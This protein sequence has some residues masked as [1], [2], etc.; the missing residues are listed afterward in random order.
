MNNSFQELWQQ[1]VA[2][3]KEVGAAQRISIVMAGLVVLLGLAGVAVWS[4]REDY[5]VL[6]GNLGE[7]EAAKVVN[8]LDEAKVPYKVRGGGTISVPADKVHPL[9]IQLAGKGIPGGGTTGFSLFDKPNFGIS[10]FVQRVNYLRAIQGELSQTIS[11]VDGI[12]SAQ[13]MLVMPE[14]RLLV[15]Y[16][17]KPSAS[18]F[19]KLRGNVPVPASTVNAIRF[20]VANAVEGLTPDGVSITDNIGNLLT[21]A[22]DND[23]I[24]GATSSQ[25]KQR[26]EYESY[27]AKKVESFLAPYV[28]GPARVLARVSVD[29]DYTTLQRRETKYDPES[30][31]KRTETITDER[32]DNSTSNLTGAVGAPGTATNANV[33][34]NSPAGTAPMTKNNTNKKVTQNQYEINEV[35]TTQNH[36]PGSTKRI[37]AAVFI[38]LEYTGEGT[39]RVAAPRSPADM[40]K[41]R[42]GIQA[43]L[44]IIERGEAGRVDDLTVEEIAFNDQPSREL[45]QQLEKSERQRL[46]TEIARESVF[47]IL[48]V[49]V[50][51]MLWRLFQKTGV[52]E[53]P[54][55][56]PIGAASAE[57]AGA[58]GGMGGGMRGGPTMETEEVQPFVMTAE[59]MNQLMRENP[60]NM[61]HALRTW[62]S[63]GAE[64][65]K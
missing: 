29:L 22:F 21:E 32:I 57:V 14:N 1:L 61:T 24:T 25:L 49:G 65:S 53:I 63:R 44:G 36:V 30:Q 7:A 51:F 50:L 3:W 17:K 23:P 2:V 35:T 54:I 27:L 58:M 15:E 10:D 5:T 33:D 8:A 9:R 41:L 13:V 16:Q 55:G 62:M 28:G 18:V 34:T 48:G 46:W 39:N 31:V 59:M 40:Q 47:P 37:S 56:I 64:K 20:L 12:E 52:D 43:A 60:N 38:P 11:R 4:S 19:L 26:R 42:R 6:Y 45:T